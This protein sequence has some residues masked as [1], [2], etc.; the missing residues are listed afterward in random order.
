VETKALEGSQGRYR[1]TRPVEAIQVPATVQV[2]L[3]AR[4]D[5]L[6]AEDK[7]LLQVAVVG[8]H[9]PFPLLQAVAELPDGTLRGALDRLQAAEFIYETGLF[10]DHEY[11]FKHAFTQDVTYNGM[12]QENRRELH[13]R[14]VGALE[15]LHQ[16]RLGEQV[17]LLAHHALGG[18]MHEKAV[19]YLFQAGVKA[20]SHSAPRNAQGSFE[21]ALVLLEEVP[22]SRFKLE[23][24][25]DIRLEL[26][27]VLIGFGETRKALQ[28]LA[29]AEAAHD[30]TGHI[31]CRIAHQGRIAGAFRA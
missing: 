21:Q 5:R 2:M 9:V 4:I 31:R 16:D 3:A 27:A 26:R 10:P 25:Y 6:S 17:E 19:S 28:R 1:L 7:R 18:E 29:R 20:A 8:R 12:L 15:I 11:S 30:R 14:I 22:D 23:Q 13:G 24:S